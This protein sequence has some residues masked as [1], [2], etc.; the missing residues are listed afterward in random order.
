M[1]EF[2]VVI[3]VKQDPDNLNHIRHRTSTAILIK[4]MM[5]YSLTSYSAKTGDRVPILA[6][7]LPEMSGDGTRYTYE[8]RPE[9]TWDDGTPITAKDY[10]FTFKAML[11]PLVNAAHYRN[12]Y[13]AVQD[14][15]VDPNNERRFTVVTDTFH[16]LGEVQCGDI[17]IMPA[18][19]YDSAGL[20]NDFTIKELKENPA[21][22]EDND[23][24]KQF[25]EIFNSERFGKVVI[26]GSGP[27]QFAEWIPGQSV[28]LIRKKEWWGDKV[29]SDEREFKAYPTR[30]I[31]QIIKD[32]EGTEAA[33]ASG[34]ID[35]AYFLP[36]TQFERMKQDKRFS[37]KFYF[38]S[39]PAYIYGYVGLNNRPPAGRKK[40]F[41]DKRVRRAMAHCLDMDKVIKEVLNGYGQ[42]TV[43]P[44]MPMRGPSEYNVNLKPVEFN[45]T[46]AEELLDEAG[47]K[48]SNGDGIRDKMINGRKV[49]MKPELLLAPNR[50]ESEKVALLLQKNAEKI[51][52]KI[53][54]NVQ[55][56][57]VQRGMY[58]NHNFD[59][60]IS[61]FVKYPMPTDLKQIW[62]TQSWYDK[63]ANFFGFGNEESDSLID[64]IR[65]TLSKDER[66]PMYYR[67]QEI[68]YDWQPVIFT[69]V[70]K[71]RIAIS[72]RFDNPQTD[73]YR[74][75]FHPNEWKLAKK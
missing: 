13:S 63:G 49:E 54:I 24:I 53:N 43:G 5:H 55:D 26:E 11:N 72:R 33:L 10:V 17:E 28:T 64:K 60:Y 27:Y 62:H 70:V 59:M 69:Y 57:Q 37:D 30:L 67:M 40:Y 2:D 31:Y 65:V 21:E 56:I 61:G 39:P 32:N 52:I 48:D 3:R 14:V 42:R 22:F 16:F 41:T 29:N 73:A 75:G 18:H 58:L 36:S 8:F 19:V 12:A 1:E 46:K 23:Q 20:M 9:A 6:K 71:E 50:E 47:W 44:V 51:G 4:R 35:V 7:A 34:D 45:L 25:A 38:Q 68:I 74:P 15:E 66:K